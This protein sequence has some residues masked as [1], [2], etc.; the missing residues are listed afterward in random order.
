MSVWK[1]LALSGPVCLF[2]GIGAFLL[3]YGFHGGVDFIYEHMVLFQLAILIGILALF[4]G[5]IGW[6]RSL[7]RQGRIRMGTVLLL[8]PIGVC[9]LGAF[10]GGTNVHGPL[11]LIFLPMF[12]IS[13]LGLVMLIIAA[14]ASGH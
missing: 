9:I 13:V 8:T 2:I 1:A 3:D 11:S 4:V 14:I 5:F 6:A 12:P 7:D 10:V